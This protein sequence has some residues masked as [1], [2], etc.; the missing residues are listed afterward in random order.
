MSKSNYSC[1]HPKNVESVLTIIRRNEFNLLR[2]VRNQN[3][4]LRHYGNSVGDGVQLVYGS[5][6][7]ELE[8]HVFCLIHLMAL[9]LILGCNRLVMA[10]VMS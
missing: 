7:N 6:C 4:G 10:E 1:Y 3:Q 8:Y 5:T 2:S 9:V